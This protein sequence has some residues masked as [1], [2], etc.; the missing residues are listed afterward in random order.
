MKPDGDTLY[1]NEWLLYN[2][3]EMKYLR[4]LKVREI[5]QQLSLSEADFYRKQRV[6]INELTRILLSMEEAIVKE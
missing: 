1:T 3:L 2:I 6:A 4:G 5:A